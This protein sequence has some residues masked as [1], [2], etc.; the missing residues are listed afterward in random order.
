MKRP[1][2]DDEWKELGK[3]TAKEKGG[4]QRFE[5]A[6]PVY[7]RYL[8]FRFLTHY[9]NEFYCTLSQIKY[10]DITDSIMPSH[11]SIAFFIL[12]NGS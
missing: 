9:G 8:L 4:E 1:R 12:E 10:V 5:L 7:A 2:E 3:F 11:L 6:N